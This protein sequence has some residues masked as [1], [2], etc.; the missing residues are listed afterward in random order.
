[1]NP[2]RPFLPG[3]LA[4]FAGICLIGLPPSFGIPVQTG[5]KQTAQEKQAIP[6]PEDITLKTRD[7]V[8]L[9]CTYFKAAPRQDEA[10]SV[11]GN[12]EPVDPG[13]VTLPFILLHDWEGSR[14]DLFAYG[15][16]L[17]KAG[18]AVIIP[19][20]RGHGE[21]TTMGDG[22]KPIDLK[23][24]RKQ[25]FANVINDIE[26]CKKFLVQKNNDGELNIDLLNVIAIG[27]TCTPAMDWAIRDWY[28]FPPYMG[29][30]KQGQDLKSLTLISPTKKL[31]QINMN[32]ALKHAMFSGRNPQI[33]NLPTLIIWSDDGSNSDSSKESRSIFETMQKGRPDVMKILDDAERAE[34][35][36]VFDI[37]I[38]S[39]QSGSD[40]IKNGELRITIMEFVAGKVGANMDQH[41]WQSRAPKKQ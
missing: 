23:K 35:E 25:D 30:I 38:R 29:K 9:K 2:L 40:L 27:K 4:F 32:Q 14:Q 28:A 10:A 12:E 13:K 19:D 33:P 34:K 7:G 39:R 15:Q 24:F 18:C 3:Y 1:M 41:P 22:M 11:V 17:Q 20:L 6:T 26:A 37:V 21:S 5:Q 16:L 31:G 8:D 36:T